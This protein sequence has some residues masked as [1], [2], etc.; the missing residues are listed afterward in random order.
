M[1]KLLTILLSILLVVLLA[2]AGLF[3][4][5]FS[6]AGNEML[7]PYVKQKLE[8]KIGMPVEVK[9]FRLQSGKSSLDL[10]IN[11]QA[12]VNVVSHYSLWGQ[13]FE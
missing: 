13:S 2:L 1:N 10:V 4:F 9:K 11:Q 7:K 6:Q 3:F 8:E 12:V 5:A